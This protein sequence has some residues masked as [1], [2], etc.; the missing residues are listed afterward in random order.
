MNKI[1]FEEITSESFDG[2]RYIVG[3]DPYNDENLNF[4]RAAFSFAVGNRTLHLFQK[5]DESISD[6]NRRINKE[7]EEFLNENRD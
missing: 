1:V 6:F 7:I 5:D 2:G 4:S 3:C